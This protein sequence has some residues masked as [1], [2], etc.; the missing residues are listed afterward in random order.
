MAFWIWDKAS[1]L[2]P[3]TVKSPWTTC[4]RRLQF[5]AGLLTLLK[6]LKRGS[7]YMQIP[8]WTPLVTKH[9]AVTLIQDIWQGYT[10]KLK[11]IQVTDGG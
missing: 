9:L 3:D 2:F 4:P 10:N 7:R 8:T 11:V 5:Q 1:H 6:Q